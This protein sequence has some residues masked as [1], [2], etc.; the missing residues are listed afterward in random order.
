MRAIISV[1]TVLVISLSVP[2]FGGNFNFQNLKGEASSNNYLLQ[3]NDGMNL[4]KPSQSLVRRGGP[5][6]L[7]SSGISYMYCVFFS[8]YS[9]GVFGIPALT[10]HPRL[11]IAELSRSSNLSVSAPVSVGLAIGSSYA[12]NYFGFELPVALD[13]NFGHASENRSRD[14]FG[15]YIGVGAAYQF[16]TVEWDNVSNFGPYAH[17]GARFYFKDESATVGLY[18]MY[19]INEYDNAISFG[20]RLLYNIGIR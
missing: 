20:L 12:Y 9:S 17:L 8:E 13:F 6:F 5:E 19:G 1:L 11:T 15:G 14:D 10:Y 16:M 2:A 4:L 18:T 3:N 7:H